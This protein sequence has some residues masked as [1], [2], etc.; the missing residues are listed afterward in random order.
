M[1]ILEGIK[2]LETEEAFARE[3]HQNLLLIAPRVEVAVADPIFKL[4]TPTTF[5]ELVSRSGDEVTINCIDADEHKTWFELLRNYASEFNVAPC[6]IL[7]V[8]SAVYSASFERATAL[9]ERAS[10]LSLV[11]GIDQVKA[12]ELALKA[13]GSTHEKEMERALR[14]DGSKARFTAFDAPKTLEL[15]LDAVDERE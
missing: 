8:P 4:S 2:L 3:K 7:D 6:I 11:E 10:Y 5:I 1:N 12:Q 9:F 14:A 15:A 13:A